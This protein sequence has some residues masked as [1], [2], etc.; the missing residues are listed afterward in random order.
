M[1]FELLGPLEDVETIA[2]GPRI[3]ELG[4]LKR[5]Y[6]DGRW[7]KM[8]GKAIIRHANGRMGLAEVH[9]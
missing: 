1:N 9:W 6:G 8:K 5:R 7:R 2:V 4:R 3:R